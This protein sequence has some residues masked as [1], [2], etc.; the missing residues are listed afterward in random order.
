LVYLGSVFVQIIRE[1]PSEAGNLGE[2]LAQ[3]R[4]GDR[5]CGHLIPVEDAMATFA[6]VEAVR[7]AVRTGAHVSARRI[8]EQTA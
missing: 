5:G 4:L 6:V 8:M 7:E 3:D 2:G 1:K